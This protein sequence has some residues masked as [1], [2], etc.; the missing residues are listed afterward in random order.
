MS[1]EK[2]D[3]SKQNFHSFLIERKSMVKQTH[4]YDFWS[5]I[6]GYDFRS[7]IYSPEY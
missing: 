2:F 4:D 1:S 5:T 7:T 3:Q 6:Y